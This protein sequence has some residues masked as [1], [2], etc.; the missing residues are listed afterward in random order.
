MTE[1]RDGSWVQD[2]SATSR[3]ELLR[4]WGRP[5]AAALLLGGFGAILHGRQGRHRPPEPGTAPAPPDWRVDPNASGRM[6]V[7]E[8]PDPAENT[9][10]AVAALGGMGAF[11]RP[12]ERVALKPNC[13]WDRR[14]EQAANTCPEV[15]A[16]L[17]RL[18]LAAGASEVVVTDNT[19]HDPDR[20]FARSGI[21]EAARD[22]GARILHQGN[23]K[24]V[25]MDLGGGILGVWEV[26]QPLADADRVINVPLIK[27]HSLCAATL[28]MKNWI[29]AIVGARANLH[30]K[31][32]L[33]MAELGAAFRPT[34]TVVDAT[35]VLTG[36]GPTG[37]SLALVR[38]AGMVAATTDP[39]AADAWGGSLLD[40]EPG[41][42]PH[43]A[44]A[45]RMGLGS[46]DWRSILVGA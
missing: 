41:R 37:G 15:V 25:D 35:R 46:P 4:W 14:P 6:A 9:R 10:R 12:G 18:S 21:E 40:L 45:G 20:T 27:H 30:Q 23:C 43:L 32:H 3:R 31:I 8:G 16:E 11:V 28:G 13:A 33:A 29:G 5:A 26:L 1:S 34:L 19:C 42:L 24:T 2:Y 36:G 44:I 39:V 22:A 38:Q 7:S 17:V